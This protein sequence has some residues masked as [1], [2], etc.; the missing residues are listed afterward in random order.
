MLRICP[1]RIHRGDS[2]IIRTGGTKYAI[3]STAQHGTTRLP[4]Q[5]LDPQAPAT[6]RTQTD[7]SGIV[8]ALQLL[9]LTGQCGQPYEAKMLTKTLGMTVSKPRMSRDRP[10][11]LSAPELNICSRFSATWFYRTSPP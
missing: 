1:L 10:R 5:P 2:S 8:F 11:L 3:V 9:E 7:D 6:W 4:F